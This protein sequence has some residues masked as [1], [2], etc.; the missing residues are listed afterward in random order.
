VS[1]FYVKFFKE[2]SNKFKWFDNQD[3]IEYISHDILNKTKY[4]TYALYSKLL[5]FDFLYWDFFDDITEMLAS[6]IYYDVGKHNDERV[7]FKLVKT[8]TLTQENIKQLIKGMNECDNASNI[9]EII[10]RCMQAYEE[11]WPC[12]Q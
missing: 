3:F 7:L 1:D 12:E 9:V 2:L 8:G 6:D 5:I 10:F 4:I 11:C